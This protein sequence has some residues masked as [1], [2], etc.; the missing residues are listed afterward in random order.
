MVYIQQDYLVIQNRIQWLDYFYNF[1]HS[2]GAKFYS[3]LF[4]AYS[5]ADEDEAFDDNGSN[6]SGSSD[7]SSEE[8]SSEIDTELEED[9]IDK[10]TSDTIY[11]DEEDSSGND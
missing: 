11:T 8:R 6:S 7:S 10:E 1:N 4:S 2:N 3:Q 5:C 9:T